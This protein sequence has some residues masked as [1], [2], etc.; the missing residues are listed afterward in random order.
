MVKHDVARM[1]G[2]EGGNRKTTPF[3]RHRHQLANLTLEVYTEVSLATLVTDSHPEFGQTRLVFSIESGLE[4]SPSRASDE[5][6]HVADDRA[7][8]SD[9]TSRA[10][11]IRRSTGVAPKLIRA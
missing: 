2:E 10:E 7:K 11:R 3:R 1:C 5:S 9:L 8:D 6:C 4:R